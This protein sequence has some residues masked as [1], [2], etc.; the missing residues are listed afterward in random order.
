[1]TAIRSTPNHPYR[2]ITAASVNC[3]AI[4]TAVVATRPMRGPATVIA[5]MM[6]AP[7]TPPS[8]IHFGEPSA[9][10]TPPSDR[11]TASSTVSATTAPMSEAVA[12]ASRAPTRSPS[13]PW[14]AIW[15]APPKPAARA[16]MPAK[17]V[18]LT[19]RTLYAP[20]VRDEGRANGP[21]DHPVRVGAGSRALRAAHRGVHQAVECDA[22]RHGKVF[23]SPFGEPK[24]RYYAEFEWADMDAF[25][26]AANSEAFAAAGKD[27]AAMGIPFTVHFASIE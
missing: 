15:T 3:A 16:R 4:R 6:S 18:E 2:S 17:A 20:R 14:T 26:A 10:P 22:F 7:M 13:R 9:S 11:R 12:T 24:Y 21:R 19:A 25:K 27:A 1:M 8:S 5:R 23:G